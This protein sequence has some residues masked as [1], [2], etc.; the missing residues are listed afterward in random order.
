MFTYREYE[1]IWKETMYYY[2]HVSNLKTY[3]VRLEN[4]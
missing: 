2:C 1:S 3:T 4:T